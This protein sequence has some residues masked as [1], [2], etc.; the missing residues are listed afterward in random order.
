MRVYATALLLAESLGRATSH[1]HA[2]PPPALTA[3]C[4]WLSEICMALAKQSA[5]VALEEG[6]PRATMGERPR[7]AAADGSAHQLE[8]AVVQDNAQQLEDALRALLG[9]R[10]A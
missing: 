2:A 1:T 10:D 3:Y 5:V 4:Q 7:P 9:S 8:W 6:D